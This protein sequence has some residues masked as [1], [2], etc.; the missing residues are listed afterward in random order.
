MHILCLYFNCYQKIKEKTRKTD[1]VKIKRDKLTFT[2]A[3]IFQTLLSSTH[4][5]EG[6]TLNYYLNGEN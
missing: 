6:T 3:G 2:I 4:S 1:N 5:I